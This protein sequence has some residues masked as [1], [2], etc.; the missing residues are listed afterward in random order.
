MLAIF[1]AQ[2]HRSLLSSEGRGEERRGKENLLSLHPTRKAANDY[3][4]LRAS[5]Q[6][7]ERE[8]FSC[9]LLPRGAITDTSATLF[10]LFSSL[11]PSF[12]SFFLRKQS[13]FV[14][15]L[16]LSGVCLVSWSVRLMF[17][18]SPPLLSSPP[19]VRGPLLVIQG[20]D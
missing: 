2:I 16:A 6:K 20:V 4:C 7:R 3:T 9:P 10:L 14:R 12:H 11:L 15:Y 8:A 17:G 13:R 18:A 5:A 19:S 1:L